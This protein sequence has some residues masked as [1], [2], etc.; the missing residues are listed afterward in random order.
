MR[1]CLNWL[2]P[3][4]FGTGGFKSHGE[5]PVQF[6]KFFLPKNR[7][8]IRQTF[9]IKQNQNDACLSDIDSL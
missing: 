5:S 7:N 8:D 4:M 1:Q 2:D 3:G 6:S 9:S